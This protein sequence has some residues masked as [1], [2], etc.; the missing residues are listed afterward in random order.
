M[1]FIIVT[2]LILLNSFFALSEIAFISSK[3]I[4][5]IESLKKGSKNAK[6]TLKYMSEPE[7]FLS[8]IQVGITLIGIISGAVG[9]LAISDD[10]SYYLQKISLISN[11]SRELSIIL[12]VGLITYLSIVI[13]EL[14][15]K[16]IA[17]RNPENIILLVIPIMNVFTNIF[18]PV[19][20]FLSFSTKVLLKIFRI[21]NPDSKNEN[22]IKE[23][24]SLTKLAVMNKKINKDQEKILFNV[25]NINK[26]MLHE[27]MVE[28]KEIKF[29]DADLNLMDAMIEA[30]IHHHTRYP[31]LDKKTGE[32]A[33]YINLK[34]IYSALQINP[35]FNKIRSISRDIIYFRDTEKVIDIF[36]KLMKKFQHIAMVKNSK[37]EI[38]GLI[39]MED[40]VETIIGDIDDE[41]KLLPEYIYK[42][43]DTR[44]IIG[45]GAKIKKLKKELGL[46]LPNSDDILSTWL[47]KLIN[48]S[49]TPEKRIKFG[50]YE[51]TVRKI[52]KNVIY[53]T[54]LQK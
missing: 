19:V 7:K 38:A 5:I 14:L 36:P 17:L 52:K 32:V 9:G 13:G 28:K 42:I 21:E 29:I 25:I 37:N 44:F 43:T 10:L 6:I 45:G 24:V 30:H 4:R 49:V 39:T 50:N 11:Y 48:F 18:Y 46:D 2:I 34:D 41:Y 26:I 33:G 51:F 1:E 22:P 20:L 8:S 31:L 53:E 15:P 54:I 35:Q 3:R 23:I 40:I 16:N 12:T 27:I 47:L